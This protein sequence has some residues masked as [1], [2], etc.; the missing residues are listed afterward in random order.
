MLAKP[1]IIA[2]RLPTA[3]SALPPR[4]DR[5]PAARPFDEL[6]TG[7]GRFRGSNRMGGGSLRIAAAPPK[8]SRKVALAA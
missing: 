6:R 5:P 1:T 7:R 4:G 3:R 2:P 8:L